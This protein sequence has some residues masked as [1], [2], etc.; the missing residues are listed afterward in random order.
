MEN[1][2]GTGG[3]FHAA[4]FNSRVRSDDVERREKW[5]G[6]L[7][8]PLGAVMLNA[9]LASY[10]NVFY[11]DVLN[12]SGIWGGLFLTV[13]PLLSKIV[14]AITNL[15]MGYII[16][17]T[18]SVQGK[19]RPWLLISA[20]LIA[21]TGILLFAVP[22]GS[23]TVQILWILL[24]YN[25]FY[26]FA[27]TIYNMSHSLMVPLST[28]NVKQRGVLSV[29]TNV[30]NVM[31]T[32]IVV[33]L[34]FPMLIMPAI[35]TN[36]QA[37]LVLMALLSILALPL[38]LL[39]YYFTKERITAEKPASENTVPYKTQVMAVFKDKYWWLIILYMFFF[40][41][42]TNIKNTSLIYYCNYVLGSYNDGI[43]Q[44]LV[45]VVGGLPMGIGLFAVWPLTKKFGK[46]NTTLAGFA[47][48]V[49]GGIICFVSPTN[50]PVVLV[51]QFIKNMGTIPASY[52][53]PAMFAD[54]LDHVEWKNGFRCD[55]ISASANSVLITVCSGLSLGV[56]NLLLGATGQY[57]APV[58]DAVTGITTGFAQSG[59]VQSVFIFGFILCDIIFYSLLV[60]ILFFLNV[61]KKMP[62]I[63]EDIRKRQTAAAPEN[64]ENRGESNDENRDERSNKNKD[65]RSNE[66]KDENRMEDLK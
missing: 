25:L 16:D 39:E 14:D 22:G 61:E 19:A 9:V 48:A 42:T 1:L 17:R 49:I 10:L 21:V 45:S 35:G 31:V 18:R 36:R 51:G 62:Q 12:L 13:F 26:S 64:D 5:L 4:R 15:A 33:A 56:F 32:G 8:G 28:R 63:Q 60:I 23:Q 27:F 46:R 24:S 40:T 6:Y 38:I 30:A 59:A 2:R 20:P 54:V 3:L 57:Q 65:E 53:F 47:L 43:T 29:F 7:I 55:G 11:T 58:Y 52:V 66:N 44:T 50:M 34:L 37:W 41:F